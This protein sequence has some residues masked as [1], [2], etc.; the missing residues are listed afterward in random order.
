[1]SEC[2]RYSVQVLL[3]KVVLPRNGY[4]HTRRE[5]DAVMERSLYLIRC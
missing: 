2:L 4:G 1:M 5:W 3:T